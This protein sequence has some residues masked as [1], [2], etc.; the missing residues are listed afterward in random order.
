MQRELAAQAA[1][2]KLIRENAAALS[3]I[4]PEDER[5]LAGQL[6]K[7][8]TDMSLPLR[9]SADNLNVSSPKIGRIADLDRESVRAITEVSEDDLPITMRG[10]IKSYDV[11]SGVGKFRYDEQPHPIPFRVPTASKEPLK[12]IILDGMKKEDVLITGYFVRD[13]Y[14]NV[15]SIILDNILEDEAYDQMNR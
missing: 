15:I 7:T 6:R 12:G 13:A 10:S 2:E 1:R 14:K 11:E 5:K 8:V 9:S 3:N 4:S